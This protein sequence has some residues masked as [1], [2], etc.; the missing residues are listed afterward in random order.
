M[1]IQSCE[2]K[3]GAESLDSGYF[4]GT[5]T[6]AQRDAT[7]RML[8]HHFMDRPATSHLPVSLRL[9][10]ILVSYPGHV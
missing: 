1:E 8:P 2:R 4:S 3:S 5:Y 7:F 10:H 9:L 6:A